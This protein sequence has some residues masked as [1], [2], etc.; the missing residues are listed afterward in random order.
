VVLRLRKRQLGK[1]DAKG[2]TRDASLDTTQML[3]WDQLIPNQ[4]TS[5]DG[6]RL[7]VPLRNW[8]RLSDALVSAG[9][10]ASF[11]AHLAS[12]ALLCDSCIARASSWEVVG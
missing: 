11:G 4:M 10:S 1:H 12:A 5:L 6:M 8:P 2:K 7:V 3:V 9:T